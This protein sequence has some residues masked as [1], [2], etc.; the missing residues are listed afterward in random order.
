MNMSSEVDIENSVLTM[1][2]KPQCIAMQHGD[3]SSDAESAESLKHE[4]DCDE[5]QSDEGGDHDE[6]A[7]DLFDDHTTL[8]QIAQ[9]Y[10]MLERI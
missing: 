1:R 3:H 10:P 7:T 4:T 8:H 2:R 5:E 9:K 6:E